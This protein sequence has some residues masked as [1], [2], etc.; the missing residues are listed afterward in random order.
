MI[1][2][3]DAHDI[4]LRNEQFLSGFHYPLIFTF[5]ILNVR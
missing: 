5:S 1:I 4:R 2:V 3:C